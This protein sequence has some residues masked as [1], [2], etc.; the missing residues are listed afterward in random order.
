MFISQ[1][2]AAIDDTFDNS[3][4]LESLMVVS[5]FC[6]LLHLQI[7][8]IPFDIIFYVCFCIIAVVS[9]QISVPNLLSVNYVP[10]FNKLM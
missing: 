9:F 8:L 2:L 10:H 6:A 1:K 5:L 4:F 7:L 3:Q